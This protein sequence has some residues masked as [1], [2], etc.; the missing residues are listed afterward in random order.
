MKFLPI[1][2]EETLKKAK[3]LQV[4]DL[5]LF[6]ASYPKSGTTWLQAVCFS[7]LRLDK[8]SE[9]LELEHISEYAPFLEVDRS[10]EDTREPSLK[11]KYNEAHKR[12]G[13]RMFNTHVLPEHLPD[14][15]LVIYIVRDPRDVCL[16]FYH[17]LSNQIEDGGD[18]FGSFENFTKLWLSGDLPYSKWVDH[19]VTWKNYIDSSQ[20]GGRVLLL[21]YEDMVKDLAGEMNKIAS[22][23]GLFNLKQEDIQSLAPELT[24]DSMKATSDKYQP[25]S[26]KWKIGYNFLRKGIVGD[27]EREFLN[28]DGSS[29]ELGQYYDECMN[30]DLETVKGPSREFVEALRGN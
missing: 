19:L 30:R 22:H 4:Q 18:D 7:L 9:E 17:H 6:I 1:S 24:F 3:S 11:S 27:A 28:E 10:W 25:V 15:G 29:T 13:R 2:S 26:V 23:L 21:R 8:A 20:S 16:S 12:L 14:N 5:D